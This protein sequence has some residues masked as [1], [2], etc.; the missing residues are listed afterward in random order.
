MPNLLYVMAG[1]ALGAGLRYEAGRLALLLF[2]GLWLVRAA[3]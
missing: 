3:A 1:G 2:L